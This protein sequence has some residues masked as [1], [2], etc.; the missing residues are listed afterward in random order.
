MAAPKRSRLEELP[1]TC[2]SCRHGH[3]MPGQ[4]FLLCYGSPPQPVADGEGGAT[5]HRGGAVEPDDPS[6]YLFSPRNRA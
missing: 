6:C 5:W 3:D 4:E 1:D 2:G